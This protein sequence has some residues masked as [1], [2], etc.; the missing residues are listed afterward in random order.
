MLVMAKLFC[1]EL[2]VFALAVVAT[3]FDVASF[4]VSYAVVGTL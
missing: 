1:F 4:V 3:F 2:F